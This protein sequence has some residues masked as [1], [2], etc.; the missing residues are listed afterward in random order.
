MR[1]RH[2]RGLTLL[3]VATGVSV[4]AVVIA[5]LLT[6]ALRMS[7][8]FEATEILNVVG[9]VRAARIELR[10]QAPTREQ[11]YQQARVP[12][13]YRNPDNPLEMRVG[14]TQ[15]WIMDTPPGDSLQI[16]RMS[17]AAC[18]EVARTLSTQA[19]RV[20]VGGN[21]VGGLENTGQI[22]NWNPHQIADTTLRTYCAVE[23][24]SILVWL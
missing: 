4:V 22:S 8:H 21:P 23:N 15:I 2:Q 5:M 24:P 10:A 14:Q 12:E 16:Y 20:R 3:D 7:T 11:I 6:S 1:R 19:Q 17:P 9:A 13:G 18:V